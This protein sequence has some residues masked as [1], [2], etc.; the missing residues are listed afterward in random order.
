MRAHRVVD[1][2]RVAQASPSEVWREFVIRRSGTVCGPSDDRDWE[3]FQ[4]VLQRD[5]RAQ[6]FFE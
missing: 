4:T 2:K 6:V 1:Q 3:A 5:M